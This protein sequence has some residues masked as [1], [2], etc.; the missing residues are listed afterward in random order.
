[1]N[2]YVI[3]VRGRPR[4]TIDDGWQGKAKKTKN[5]G[6]RKK[7]NISSPS[8]A[9]GLSIGFEMVEKLE[10]RVEAVFRPDQKDVE[11]QYVLTGQERH[12]PDQ[13]HSLAADF[14]VSHA[15]ERSMLINFRKV[16]D[17][18]LLERNGKTG[19]FLQVHSHPTT[20]IPLPSEADQ[21][22]WQSVS[23]DVAT[24]FPGSNILFGVHGVG[25]KQ[26]DFIERTRPS[27]VSHNTLFWSSN[28]RQ[29]RLGIFSASS[30]PQ[31]L[32]YVD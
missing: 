28:T 22:M 30:K 31:R 13:L 6:R 4:I 20:G 5:V 32:V 7:T 14:I 18:V 9:G 16:I 29:H 19:M 27:N 21:D 12:T 25:P 10:I 15:D 26:S 1:M 23:S 11:V 8:P 17:A 2:E 24:A 3:R